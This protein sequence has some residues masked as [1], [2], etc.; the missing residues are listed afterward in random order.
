MLTQNNNPTNTP[1]N[2]QMPTVNNGTSTIPSQ[3]PIQPEGI[4]APTLSTY[5]L[6]MFSFFCYNILRRT[7]IQEV[8]QKYGILLLQEVKCIYLF[9]RPKNANLE[10]KL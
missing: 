6:N 10:R 7:N 3:R 8:K 4:P 9:R 1:H 5:P 2:S